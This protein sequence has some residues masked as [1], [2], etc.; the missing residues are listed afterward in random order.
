MSQL[1]TIIALQLPRASSPTNIARKLILLHQGNLLFTN[2]HITSMTMTNFG[3]GNETLAF[4]LSALLCYIIERPMLQKRIHREI[5]NVLKTRGLQLSSEGIWKMGK[6]QEE[7]PLLEACVR[8]SMRLHPV[9]GIP[10]P[11]VVGLGGIEVD[12]VFVPA[13]VSR[14]TFPGYNVTILISTSKTVVGINQWAVAQSEELYGLDAAEFNPER[15]LRMSKE[16]K[17]RIGWSFLLI[18]AASISYAILNIMTG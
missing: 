3:A 17:N 1:R 6:A 4:T 14:D 13:G 16:D 5:D 11:R 9:F 2:E 8:E 10:L 18:P 15:W 7:L 12:G